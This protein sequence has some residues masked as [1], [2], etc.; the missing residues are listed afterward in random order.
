MKRWVDG[1]QRDPDRA[2]PAPPARERGAA[3]LFDVERGASFFYPGGLVAVHAQGRSR[4]AIWDALMRR[5]TYATSGPRI[6]LWF[7][8]A[9]APGGAAPMGSEVALASAPIFR[10]RAVGAF[11]QQPGCPAETQR[12]LST[13]RIARLCGGECFHPSD[14]RH[15]IAA[16]E[17]VRVR[18]Q[19]SL[20]EP[21]AARIEDP[22]RRYACRPDPAGCEI[23]FDDP[24]F[25]VDG[26]DTVY[27]VRAL[28]EPTPA[29]NGAQLR[30][31]FAASGDATAVAPCPAGWRAKGDGD[32]CLAP[33]QE[34]AWSSPIFVDV[35]R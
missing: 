29:I 3:Q 28:Q 2:Q 20:A 18:P 10:V 1:T 9:N 7:E 23:A 30:T 13:E 15:R 5:E 19:Q 22:W 26:R 6:L 25:A 11:A 17:V 24:D 31:R 21:V 4:Q 16:I 8:L 34:R 32:D 12:A 33:V 27:Y 14:E 35:A